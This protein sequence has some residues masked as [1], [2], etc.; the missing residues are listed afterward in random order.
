MCLR[1]NFKWHDQEVTRLMAVT[2]HE[3]IKPWSGVGSKHQRR[4]PIIREERAALPSNNEGL[5]STLYS[6]STVF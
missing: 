2:V 5:E 1:Y 6:A 4:A 3:A